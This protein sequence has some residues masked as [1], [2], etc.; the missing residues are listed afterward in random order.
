M[1]ASPNFFISMVCD[2]TR[3]WAATLSSRQKVR[4]ISLART[5]LVRCGPSLVPNRTKV[6]P[7]TMLMLKKPRSQKQ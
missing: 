5:K 3:C 2:I 7:K 4:N 1:F 6:Y